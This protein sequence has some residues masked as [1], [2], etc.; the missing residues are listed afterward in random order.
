MKK[1]TLTLAA[2]ALA[3]GSMALSAKGSITGCSFSASAMA[4]NMPRS[5]RPA[6]PRGRLFQAAASLA[7]IG[8]KRSGGRNKSRLWQIVTM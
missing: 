7:K 3:L 2:A 5:A 4:P 8:N 1:L 6:S